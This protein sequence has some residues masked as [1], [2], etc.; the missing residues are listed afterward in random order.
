MR[1]DVPGGTPHCSMMAGGAAGEQQTPP[2]QHR[3][4]DQ[5]CLLCHFPQ[6]V[7]PAPMAVVVAVPAPVAR[8]VAWTVGSARVSPAPTGKHARARAP[9]SFS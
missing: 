4:S 1:A 2:G 6:A 9:P 8:D 5:C 7:D 3:H